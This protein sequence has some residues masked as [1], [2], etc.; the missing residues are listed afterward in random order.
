MHVRWG[1]ARVPI[2]GH[3]LRV[4]DN[5]FTP[6]TVGYHLYRVASSEERLHPPGV[7]ITFTAGTW[8]IV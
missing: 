7:F 3:L 4:F 5:G 2:R 6:V 8:A 1:I